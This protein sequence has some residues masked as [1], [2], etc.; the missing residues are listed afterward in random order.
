M[1]WHPSRRRRRRGGCVLHHR[2]ARPALLTPERCP[3]RTDRESIGVVGEAI[4]TNRVVRSEQDRLLQGIL[5]LTNVA[6]PAAFTLDLV[7]GQ[8]AADAAGGIQRHEALIGGAVPRQLR[9]D[10][11]V[12]QPTV[13]WTQGTAFDEQVA[14]RPMFGR[15][16]GLHGGQHILGLGQLVLEGQHGEQQIVFGRER[17]HAITAPWS[18]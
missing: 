11:S 1:P 16:P 10:E 12:Q 13:L 3:D 15:D 6:R 18:V 14:Q 7:R 4:R 8:D 9:F 2:L 17:G 5:Q